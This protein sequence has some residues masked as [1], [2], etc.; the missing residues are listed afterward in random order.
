ML[1]LD[2]ISWGRGSS[3]YTHTDFAW[4]WFIGGRYYFTDNLAAMLELGYSATYVNI[5]VA[6][7]FGN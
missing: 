2:Y 3:D 4:G 7:K 6:Y 5:G 1:G